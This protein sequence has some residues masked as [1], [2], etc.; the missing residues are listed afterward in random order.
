MIQARLR[1]EY[2]TD[3]ADGDLA[4]YAPDDPTCFGIPLTA[5][6]GP[7]AG[8]GEEVFDF[9]VCTP[10]WLAANM[11]A[12]GYEWGRHKLIVPRWD[13]EVVRGAITD[14]CAKAVGPDWDAVVTRLARYGAWE[15]EDDNLPPFRP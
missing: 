7:Q 1:G 4:R 3:V 5:A 13:F 12:R 10:R 11:P 15:F 6:I 9:F 2:S 8:Q 14:L